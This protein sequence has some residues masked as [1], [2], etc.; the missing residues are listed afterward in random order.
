MPKQVRRYTVFGSSIGFDTPKDPPKPPTDNKT[1]KE[2][3]SPK[4]F[5]RP[6][7]SITILID[8]PKIKAKNNINI[9]NKDLNL[10]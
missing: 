5:N 8:I 3:V 1:P 4:L 7:N 6:S 2:T 9:Y 10:T